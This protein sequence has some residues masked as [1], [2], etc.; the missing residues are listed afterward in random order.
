MGSQNVTNFAKVH[1]LRA[2]NA[3]KPYAATEP[4]SEET[5]TAVSTAVG[6]LTKS[7]PFIKAV[8][9][10][11]YETALNLLL[12]FAEDLRKA[13]NPKE[14]AEALE[15][16]NVD[17]QLRKPLLRLTSQMTK[18]LSDRL[19][20]QQEDS[21]AG[22][23]AKDAVTKTL[24]DV[25]AQSL[26][27]GEVESASPKQLSNAFQKLDRKTLAEIFYKNVLSSLTMLY[28]DAAK[29][30]RPVQK[31]IEPALL[32][33]SGLPAALSREVVDLAGN[34]PEKIRA[35]VDKRVERA[36]TGKPIFKPKF[37]PEP[38]KKPKTS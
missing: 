35:E 9:S 26:P 22:T 27:A 38:R 30:P 32:D 36:K 17:P 34:K 21:D 11:G 24:I 19:T 1:M 28:L 8:S 12:S 31:K 20:S 4:T 37:D 3:F 16:H 29:V 15:K 2:R 6:P 33:E 18:T 14:L 10:K 5:W 7:H 23:A 25:L 13:K